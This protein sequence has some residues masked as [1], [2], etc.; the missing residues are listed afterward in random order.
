MSGNKSLIHEFDHVLI[1]ENAGFSF[2]VTIELQMVQ[3][4]MSCF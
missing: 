4:V 3:N 2:D 1:L